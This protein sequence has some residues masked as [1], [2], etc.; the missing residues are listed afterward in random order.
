MA[1]SD[2]DKKYLDKRQQQAVLTYTAQY[3]RA[4]REGNRQAAQMAHEG[5]EAIRRLAGYSGGGRG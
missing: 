3:E 5:A 4:I 1:L 2:Y